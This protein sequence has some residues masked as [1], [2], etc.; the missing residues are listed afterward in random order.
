[1]FELYHETP[2]TKQVPCIKR[3]NREEGQQQFHLFL[4]LSIFGGGG[5]GSTF[6]A[7]FTSTFSVGEM[8]ESQAE[9]RM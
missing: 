3:K 4:I 5:G 7:S 2:K 9:I 8:D 6:A 1:M